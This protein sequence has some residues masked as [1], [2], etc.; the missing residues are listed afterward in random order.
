MALFRKPI[1]PRQA[2]WN[3]GAEFVTFE[4]CNYRVLE[5]ETPTWW[6]NQHIGQIRQGIEITDSTGHVFLIDN[7]HGE[8]YR[9]LIE[10]GGSP[11][12]NHKSVINYEIVDKDLDDKDWHFKYD[13]A[14]IKAEFEAHENW[15]RENHFEA[16]ERLRKM[17]ES[18]EE[19]QKNGFR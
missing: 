13:G 17:R 2:L 10:F 19:Q 8:G 6:P 16:F 9:K 15:M 1:R 12:V 14:A 3:G 4:F 7:Q 18:F 11:K 5:H